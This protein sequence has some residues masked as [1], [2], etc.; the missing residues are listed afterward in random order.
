MEKKL[1][2]GIPTQTEER[3]VVIE[4]ER[5]FGGASANPP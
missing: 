4:V 1:C 3:K 5:H 2:D